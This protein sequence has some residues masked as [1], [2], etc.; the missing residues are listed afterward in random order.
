MRSTKGCF[1][2]SRTSSQVSPKPN[3]VVTWMGSEEGGTPPPPRI[4]LKLVY[5]TLGAAS[6]K[7]ESMKLFTQVSIRRPA[8]VRLQPE[9]IL[10][11]QV[12]S[13]EQ[14]LSGG[15]SCSRN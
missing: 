14:L 11:S 4:P 10:A 15:R 7:L 12:S 6:L 8:M 3:A 5:S 9:E 13:S 2:V 1:A